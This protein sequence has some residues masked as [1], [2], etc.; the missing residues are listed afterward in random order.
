MGYTVPV[1]HNKTITNVNYMSGEQLRE[2]VSISSDGL[3]TTTIDLTV[4]TQKI[5]VSKVSNTKFYGL[6]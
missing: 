5:H 3:K 6:W 1:L 4:Q 2:E